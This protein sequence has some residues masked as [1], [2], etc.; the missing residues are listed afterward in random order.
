M[1]D[2]KLYRHLLGLEASWTVR[3][4]E[5]DVPGYR[6]DVWAGRAEDVRWPCPECGTLPGLYDHSVER[7]GWHLDRCPFLTSS[8]ARPPWG[9]VSPPVPG[10]GAGPVHRRLRP[11]SLRHGRPFLGARL[12]RLFVLL[13]V[14]RCR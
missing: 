12:L 13:R 3:S 4:V 2:V 7:V 1:R 5:L 8:S 10:G 14:R 9:P 11:A 6:L